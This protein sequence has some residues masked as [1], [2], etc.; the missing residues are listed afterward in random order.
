MD[1]IQEIFAY[2]FLGYAALATLLS[3][4]A[5]GIVGTY[6]V[7]RKLVFMS[8]GIT[9]A[10]FGGIG[11]AYYFGFAPLVGAL[12]FAVAAAVGIETFS[13]RGKVNEDAATGILWSIGMSIGIIFIFLTPGYAP[14]L[15]SFLFGNILLVNRT[16]LIGLGIMDGILLLLF[17]ACYRAIL[18]TAFD[19][20][21]AASQR[22]PVG[23]IGHTMMILIAVTIVLTIKTMGIVLLMSLLTLPTVIAGMLTRNYKQ[24]TIGSCI[25]GTVSVLVGLYISYV[26]NIPIGAAAIAVLSAAFCLVKAG[27]YIGRK[28]RVISRG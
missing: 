28:A 22:L 3:G 24:L 5:C 26:G 9:H 12:L 8:G 15:M 16:D 25:G 6:I 27:V 4:I 2:R 19:R 1:F 14:N 7:S 21:F 18:Y 10:S 11:I 20:E 23:A 13:R 17:A